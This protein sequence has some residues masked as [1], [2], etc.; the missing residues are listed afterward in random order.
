LLPYAVGE[1][2]VA[3][4]EDGR[5]AFT[6]E[7]GDTVVALAAGP[8][9]LAVATVG[10]SVT[11][12]DAQGEIVGE[13]T[14]A[15]EIDAVRVDRLRVVVQRGRTLEARGGSLQRTWLLPARA[16]LQDLGSNRIVYVAAGRAYRI[17]V[18]TGEQRQLGAGTLAQAE[19]AQLFVASGRRVSLTRFR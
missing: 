7:T 18:G 5:R 12:L 15:G 6:Y 13:E 2:V 8:Q 1:T 19:G 3:L 14:F 17:A 4:R 16:Q 9:R 11:V 10:G